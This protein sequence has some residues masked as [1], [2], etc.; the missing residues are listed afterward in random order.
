MESNISR[1]IKLRI[2]YGFQFYFNPR[3]HLNMELGYGGGTFLRMGM[4]IWI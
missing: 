1:D 2:A 4:G 3:I